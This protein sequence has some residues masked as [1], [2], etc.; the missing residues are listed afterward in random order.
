MFSILLPFS[1]GVAHDGSASHR[2][3][4]GGALPGMYS[5]ERAS[6]ASHGS[7]ARRQG[8]T[9][10]WQMPSSMR[11]YI[12]PLH[13]DHMY[14][15]EHIYTTYKNI[16]PTRYRKFSRNRI[17]FWNTHRKEKNNIFIVVLLWLEWRL[18]T[19]STH[20][21]SCRA[22]GR[23]PRGEEVGP[24]LMLGCSQCLSCWGWLSVWIFTYSLKIIKIS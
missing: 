7:K 22:G 2:V 9:V 8:G 23:W 1:E 24:V 3:R 15:C 12:H 10:K 14:T 20:E 4:E 16:H 21:L 13:P 5:G 17:C 11:P 6:V 19:S 18:Q